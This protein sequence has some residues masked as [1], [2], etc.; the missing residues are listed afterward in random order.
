MGFTTIQTSF[1]DVE[2][3]LV[4]TRLEIAGFSPFLKDENATLF[5]A[6]PNTTG[7]IKIQVPDEEAEAAANFLRNEA[8]E[9]AASSDDS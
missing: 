9:N 1:S 4:K 2:A 7:G 3:N 8:E 5:T 6:A